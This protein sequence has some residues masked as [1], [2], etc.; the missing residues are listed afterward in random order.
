MT[1]KPSL[2]DQSPTLAERLRCVDCGRKAVFERRGQFFCEEH[3][4]STPDRLAYERW[5]VEPNS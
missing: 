2:P 4:L 1:A 5:F 3:L